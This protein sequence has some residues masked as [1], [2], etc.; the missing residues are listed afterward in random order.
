MVAGF[1]LCMSVRLSC[2]NDAE[3]ACIK[4]FYTGGTL[5]IGLVGICGNCSIMVIEARR[6]TW[7]YAFMLQLNIN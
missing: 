7:R 4:F 6:I 2:T 3:A 1:L 5:A